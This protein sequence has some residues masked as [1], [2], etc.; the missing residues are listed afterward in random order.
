MSS[1]LKNVVSRMEKRYRP[2]LYLKDFDFLH[3]VSGWKEELSKILPE[4]L[5]PGNKEFDLMG[6]LPEYEEKIISLG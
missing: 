4:Y 3:Q 2:V 1:S 5:T 6:Y